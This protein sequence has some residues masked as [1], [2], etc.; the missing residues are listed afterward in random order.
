MTV[1]PGQ[2]FARRLKKAREAKSL[3]Q[4]QLASELGVSKQLISHWENGRWMPRAADA[5]RLARIL[6]VTLDWLLLDAPANVNLRVPVTVMV[7][8]PTGEQ[9][10]AITRGKL[11]LQKIERCWLANFED[12]DLTALDVIDSGMTP[13]IPRGAKVLVNS[14]LPEPGDVCV[15]V[16][17]ATGEILIRRYQRALSTPGKL[18]FLLAADNSDYGPPRRIVKGDR[19]KMFGTV[20]RVVID[21]VR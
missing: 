3:T 12:V 5:S 10:V 21:L 8:Y 19:P 7:P 17:I 15:V 20:F 14:R 16:L 4:Q 6:G 13:M 2:A 1:E 11:D 9:L 18:P